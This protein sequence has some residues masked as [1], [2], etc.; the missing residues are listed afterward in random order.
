ML[1]LRICGA[2]LPLSLAFLSCGSYAIDNFISV[3]SVIKRQWLGE[4]FV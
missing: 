2:I 3:I 4:M 1:R